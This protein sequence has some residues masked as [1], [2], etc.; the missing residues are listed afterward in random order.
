MSDPLAAADAAGWVD[1]A[2]V[3]AAVFTRERHVFWLDAGPGARDGW[4]WMGTGIP[5]DAAHVRAVVCGRRAADA[6]ASPLRGGWVGWTGYDD[7]AARAGAPSVRD[8]DAL[9]PSIWLRVTRLVAFDHAARRVQVFA[10]PDDVHALAE[11]VAAASASALPV[12]AS[13]AS[14]PSVGVARARHRPDQY[15][16]LIEECRAAI[17]EGDAYQ[18]CLTT[19]FEVETSVDPVAAYARLRTA[20]PAHH[21]GFLRSGE[22]ALLSASPERFLQ[23]AR[24]ADEPVVR[25]SPIKG[26][27]P[28]GADP[29]ADAALADDLRSSEKERAENVM[30][31]D[32]MRNDLSR[33]CVP[34]TVGVDAL[35]EVESYPAVHQLVSTVSGTLGAGTTLGDLLDATFPAGSMTGAPKL[36]AMTILHRLERAPRGVFSGCFGW[37]GDDGALDLAMVI[38]SIVVRPGGAYVGAG[39]GITWRSDAAAEVAEVGIKARG[40]LA[41]LGAALPPGW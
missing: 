29:A 35:L 38:R 25:T 13:P 27:R 32:L 16:A 36:S 20:T 9:P 24:T 37:V 11:A 26:T 34:G 2:S 33:V 19:R 5:D 14:A 41:A 4:S 7:A 6:G 17:R 30:I 1:P 8:D 40:P 15:A 23:V 28:R 18:L 12:P 31:V 21:G 3:F 39:G 22:V 10:G